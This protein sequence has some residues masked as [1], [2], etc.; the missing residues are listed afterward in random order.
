MYKLKKK[1]LK[2]SEYFVDILSKL[3]IICFCEVIATNFFPIVWFKHLNCEFRIDGWP[4]STGKFL[5]IDKKKYSICIMFVFNSNSILYILFSL[6]PSMTNSLWRCYS[7]PHLP[8]P[9]PPPHL[10]ILILLST[11]AQAPSTQSLS[12]VRIIGGANLNQNVL[13]PPKYW[14]TPPPPENTHI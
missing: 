3:L 8:N 14:F 5:V 13:R 12:K 6:S 2:I 4:Q 10:R 11:I 7:D 9:P 1:I